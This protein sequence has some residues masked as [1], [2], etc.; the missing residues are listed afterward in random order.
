[1]SSRVV[2]AALL[3]N[4]KQD[5][6]H[7]IVDPYASDLIKNNL[8]GFQ[9]TIES[10]VELLSASFFEQL[11]AND[12]LFIDSGHCVRIGG[13]VNYLYL[14]IL[15]RLA[16]GVIVHIHDVQLPY[17][18][19]RVYAV[20]ET[21]RQFWTEQYLLQSFL[22]FNSEFE[23]LLGMTYLMTDHKEVFKKAFPYYDPDLRISGSFWIR[24]K[25]KATNN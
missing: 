2:A 13:D 17:E 1:M 19:P 9:Q 20:N 14:D 15:P 25:V 4:Q 23:V 3:L 10:R 22:C 24:R 5:S 11:K 12:I 18:Y 6:K 7:M 8:K 16:P 21:F